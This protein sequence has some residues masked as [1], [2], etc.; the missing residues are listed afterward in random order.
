MATDHPGEGTTPVS[1]T[2]AVAFRPR[3]L[4]FV[5]IFST[6]CSPVCA[7]LGVLVLTGGFVS[8]RTTPCRRTVTRRQR[9]HAQRGVIQTFFFNVKMSR[10]WCVAPMNVNHAAL[11]AQHSSTVRFPDDR[12]SPGR[13]I[14][15][16]YFCRGIVARHTHSSI[17]TYARGG[18]EQRRVQMAEVPFLGRCRGP[19]LMRWRRFPF[20]GG[21]VVLC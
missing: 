18:R 12:Q 20:L 13:F 6:F 19:L 21:E 16:W 14:L 7:M 4:S 10:R 5:I 11:L 3:R 15:V 1:A 17:S 8:S 9:R 2:S